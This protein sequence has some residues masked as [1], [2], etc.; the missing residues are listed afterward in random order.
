MD[1]KHFYRFVRWL[2]RNTVRLQR[3]STTFINCNSLHL[4]PAL[5]QDDVI[6]SSY[7]GYSKRYTKSSATY[8]SGL[9]CLPRLQKKM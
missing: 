2:E 9:R 5:R 6:Q 4:L 1:D 8:Y 3:A 7:S